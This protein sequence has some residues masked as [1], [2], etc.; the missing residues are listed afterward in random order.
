MVY[1]RNKTIKTNVMDREVFLENEEKTCIHEFWNKIIIEKPHFFNGDL[2]SVEAIREDDDAI[3]IDLAKS[4]FAHYLYTKSHCEIVHPCVSLAVG[5]MI[6]SADGYFV[7]G[8][9][10]SQT[11]TP[12][13][14]Q[15]LGGAV[16]REDLFIENGIQQAALREIIEEVGIDIG[17]S[18]E[19]IKPRFIEKSIGVC[20]ILLMAKSKF[21]SE[22]LSKEFDQFK[23][24]QQTEE[25]NSIYMHK[26]ENAKEMLV[27]EYELDSF[28]REAICSV[29]IMNDLQDY[30]NE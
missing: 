21:S 27:G 14:I 17:D 22:K 6:V 23:R 30:L 28:V 3:H 2:L 12:K 5:T 4:S 19:S 13:V 1:I 26:I 18:I 20:G 10:G 15:F 8:I 9:T 11:E 7:F 24:S 29:D 25:M 16:D